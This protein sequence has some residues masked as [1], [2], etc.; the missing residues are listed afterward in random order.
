MSSKLEGKTNAIYSAS[1][2]NRMILT[3]Y[4]MSKTRVS[5][6]GILKITRNG[7]RSEGSEEE[8]GGRGGRE[9][10]VGEEGGNKIF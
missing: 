8:R 10:G 4:T 3:I 7:R 9:K 2:G 6:M 1:I 5:N